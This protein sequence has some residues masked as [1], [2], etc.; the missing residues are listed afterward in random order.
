MNA[1]D[2]HQYSIDVPG[3]PVQDLKVQALFRL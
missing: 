2:G 3:N 1:I